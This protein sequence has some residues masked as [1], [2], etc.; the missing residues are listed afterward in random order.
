[1]CHLK[2]ILMSAE[3][4]ERNKLGMVDG[5]MFDA[6]LRTDSKVITGVVVP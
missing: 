6:K 3:R 5:A 4:R 1:M 2:L